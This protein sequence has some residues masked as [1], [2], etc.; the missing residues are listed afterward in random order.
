MKFSLV[1]PCYNES[2]KHRAS[3]RSLQE[4]RGS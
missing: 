1:I 4:S 3:I 2:K